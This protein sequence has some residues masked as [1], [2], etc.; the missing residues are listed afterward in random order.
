MDGKLKLAKEVGADVIINSKTQ[1]LR[2]VGQSCFLVSTIYN[3][4]LVMKET[5]GNGVGR[6]IEATGS[7]ELAGTCFTCLRYIY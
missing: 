5:G 3:V 7:A 2:D 4:F 6:I 1:N